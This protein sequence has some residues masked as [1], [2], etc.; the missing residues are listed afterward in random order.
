LTAKPFW[1]A[2][3]GQKVIE[4]IAELNRLRKESD[5]L[6]KVPSRKLTKIIVQLETMMEGLKQHEDG[7]MLHT[8]LR[9]ALNVAKDLQSA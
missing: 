5:A 3:P 1:E 6:S 7:W 2:Y 8:Y 4:E 9:D